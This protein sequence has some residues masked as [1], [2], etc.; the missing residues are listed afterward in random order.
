M[1]EGKRMASD[2]ISRAR[3][4]NIPLP[5]DRANASDEIAS[6]G[7]RL[8]GAFDAA[9]KRLRLITMATANTTAI[10]ARIVDLIANSW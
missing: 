4:S 10:N 3:V 7:F 5:Q 6:R 8:I 1:A 2:A 9:P